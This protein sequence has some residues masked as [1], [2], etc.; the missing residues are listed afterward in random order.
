MKNEW[1]INFLN[2]SHLGMH[3]IIPVSFQFVEENL[4]FSFDIL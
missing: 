1:N 4:N 2:N 3:H